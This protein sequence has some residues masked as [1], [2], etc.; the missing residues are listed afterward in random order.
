[1]HKN[2]KILTIINFLIQKQQKKYNSCF[3]KKSSNIQIKF[4]YFLWTNK[5]IY[6]YK[7]V[8]KNYYIIFLKIRIKNNKQ[9][10]KKYN[11]IQTRKNFLLK[12]NWNKNNFFL[13]HQNNMFFTLKK[14][15]LLKI[16]GFI[17]YKIS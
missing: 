2:K 17:S 3:F 4:L 13:I 9:I 16:G 5:F 11:Y 6:G 14:I 10:Y 8:Q 12:K 1:M 7:E 15:I